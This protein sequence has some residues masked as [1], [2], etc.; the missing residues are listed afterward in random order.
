MVGC[1]AG[2]FRVALERGDVFRGLFHEPANW[3][4]SQRNAEFVE[5]DFEPGHSWLG[6]LEPGHADSG[7]TKPCHTKPRHSRHAQSSCAAGHA[8][9]DQL[10]WPREQ[11]I[12]RSGLW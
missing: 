1:S 8:F 2:V 11:F 12:L 5:H 7:H 4:R 6:W 3:E 9:W 10:E